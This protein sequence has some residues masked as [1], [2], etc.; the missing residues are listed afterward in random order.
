MSVTYADLEHLGEI[1]RAD[2]CRVVVLGS[3][4]RTRRTPT[5]TAV[6]DGSPHDASGA[7][8]CG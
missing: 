4:H 5:Q 3:P 2:R 8:L 1:G 6:V 7:T